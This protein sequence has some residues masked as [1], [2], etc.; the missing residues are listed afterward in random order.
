MNPLPLDL[1]GARE[2]AN[3]SLSFG[4]LLPGIVGQDGYA[5]SV[6][7]QH[8]ADQ[9]AGEIQPIVVPLVHSYLKGYD[10][11][12]GSVIAQEGVD[13]QP[14]SHWGAFGRYVYNLRVVSPTG[15]V[16]DNV[17][18]PFAREYGPGGLSAV[19]L[20][21]E[22]HVWS[23]KE[24][25]WRTPPQA[26]LVMYEIM[27]VE[28]ARNLE[29]T[30]SRL[31][32]LQDLGIN[33][34]SLMPI[35]QAAHD[36]GWG[37]DPIGYF[38]IHEKLGD[39]TAFK[40]L[41]DEAHQRGIAVIV[42]AVYGHASIDFA[43]QSLY[44]QLGMESPTNGPEDRFGPCLDH[45][46]PLT[47]DLAF[48]ANLFWLDH[49]HV[50]GFRYDEVAAIGYWDGPTGKGFANLTY[51]VYKEVIAK[52]I[53]FDSGFWM[54]FAGTNG[55]TLIQ[56]AEYHRSPEV[57]ERTYATSTWQ[58][59]TLNAAR[60]CAVGGS[61]AIDR[62]G[63]AFAAAGF[64]D[65]H[66]NRDDTIPQAPL[67]YIESHD[68]ERLICAFNGP[69]ASDPC[70]PGNRSAWPKLQPY[71]IGLLT[72]KGIPMLWQGE[73]FGESYYVPK[74]DPYRHAFR[75]IRWRL[76]CEES[77]KRLHELVRRI[78]G[79]REKGDQFRRGE[80]W[81]HRDERWSQRGLLLFSRY[82]A[83]SFSLVALNFTD[84]DL[85]S[86]FWFTVPGDYSEELHGLNDLK[87]VMVG[88]PTQIKVPSNYGCI[89]TL[90]Q[91]I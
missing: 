86:E 91:P 72:S 8:T 31:D 60:E 24:V 78:I 76:L 3:R 80:C 63:D 46:K 4:V 52:V 54:R 23:S 39:Q 45:T 69:Q 17:S 22:D 34:I 62:L 18:D 53:S 19:S 27:V 75:P 68:H 82:T 41:V 81:Y 79:I 35:T 66:V 74:S 25:G 57:L 2:T 58:N 5:V 51:S 56:C 37:Y 88:V 89:W 42:D 67:Q 21:Q 55:L 14:G 44:Y 29:G 32:Y 84:Q 85:S 36:V 28:F 6:C 20:G 77:G 15:Q 90:R 10:Y 13:P 64:P 65:I 30:V 59:R 38:G 83:D 43:Y 48:S 33:C 26:D 50:D 47:Q 9:L 70:S 12:S 73:E 1:I 16:V 71:L 11:W 49:F 7:V 40:R 61:G 87:A